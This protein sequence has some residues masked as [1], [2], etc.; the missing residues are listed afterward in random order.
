M[1]E[2]ISGTVLAE[3]VLSGQLTA[4]PVVAGDYTIALSDIP[5]GHRLTVTRGG[6]TQTADIMDGQGELTPHN[7]L[8]GRDAENAHPMAA[9]TGLEAALS[10]CVAKFQG[11]SHVGEIL[12]V[13]ANGELNLSPFYSVV[14][15][16]AGGNTFTI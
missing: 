12:K 2:S 15:N 4:G 13:D 1:S 9:I 14:A 6:Q 5:G 7:S 10:G 8:S 11:A 16:D 3:L